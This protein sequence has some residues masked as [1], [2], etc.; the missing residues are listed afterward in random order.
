MFIYAK[1]L[2]QSRESGEIQF[3]ENRLDS[4]LDDMNNIWLSAEYLTGDKMTVADIFGV[5]DLEQISELDFRNRRSCQD[6]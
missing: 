2:G 3:L 6:M 5:C 4:V 1:W